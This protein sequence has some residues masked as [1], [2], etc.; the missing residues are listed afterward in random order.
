MV[1]GVQ[2]ENSGQTG[3]L[4][5]VR[6]DMR[7]LQ[8][9]SDGIRTVNEGRT[10]RNLWTEVDGLHGGELSA[11]GGGN[12]TVS[13]ISDG[14]SFSEQKR[15]GIQGFAGQSVRTDDSTSDRLRGNPEMGKSEGILFGQHSDEGKSFSSG[16][17]SLEEKLNTVFSSQK[18]EKTSTEKADVFI[19][20]DEMSE[21][22]KLEHITSEIAEKEKKFTDLVNTPERHYDLISDTAKEIYESINATV[23]DQYLQV[24]YA[25]SYQAYSS[26]NYEDAKTGF[27]KVVEMDET[28]QDGNAIYYLAQT[29]R[30]LGEN[31]KAIEY[32]QK[33]MDGYPNTERA[34]N[35]SRYLEELQKAEQ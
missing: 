14:G 24:T 2:N 23:N 33:V 17:R 34:S 32:Y 18:T 25:E 4:V 8:P 12:E 6:P 31:E 13:Q 16:D 19:L 3:I 20:G 15:N 11:S 29:Y 22:E 30:N 1:S 9:E 26:H 7:T 21:Q 27:E 10:D 5:Q 35:S 28:Y